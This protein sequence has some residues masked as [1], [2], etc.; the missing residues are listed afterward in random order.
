[1]D[2]KSST[3]SRSPGDVEGEPEAKKSR[4]VHKTYVYSSGKVLIHLPS[5][6]NTSYNNEGQDRSTVTGGTITN[7]HVED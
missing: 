4:L 6:H 1:M 7:I 5:H 2:N 3:S